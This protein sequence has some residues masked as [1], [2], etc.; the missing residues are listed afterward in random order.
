M[1]ALP[2]TALLAALSLAVPAVTEAAASSEVIPYYGLDCG[3]GAE[4]DPALPRPWTNL[5][6][7]VCTSKHLAALH[8]QL[9]GLLD[10]AAS[11]LR[12][13][14]TERAKERCD[15]AFDP[16]RDLEAK[17]LA[18]DC[19]AALYR[20]LIRQRGSR[21][22]GNVV[23]GPL[24]D[25]LIHP[26][27]LDDLL[28]LELDTP[29]RANLAPCLAGTKRVTFI[30]H[31]VD[32]GNETERTIIYDRWSP[33][34]FS[35]YL[36]YSHVGRPTS[37]SDLLWTFENSGGR[38]RFHSL[39][40]VKG[41]LARRERATLEWLR[42][43]GEAYWVEVVGRARFGDRCNGSLARVAITGPT[44]VRASV[45][46]TPFALLALDA[47]HGWRGIAADTLVLDGDT[48]A[49]AQG[50]IRLEAGRDL[51]NDPLACIGTADFLVDLATGERQFTGAVI[52]ELYYWN[53]DDIRLQAC[54]NYLAR[55]K[56]TA[57][58]LTLTPQSLATLRD[59]FVARCAV[60]TSGTP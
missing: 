22:V 3:G 54:F 9:A 11:D 38:A 49:A 40:L 48:G 28:A 14:M 18:S 31:A 60:P 44:T 52:D 5:N 12:V 19:L 1:R 58:P 2:A 25:G 50:P 59:A 7:L 15:L 30:Y 13:A 17:W 51:V 43:D 36:G 35:G 55:S 29:Y 32:R 33:A 47:Y 34:A 41:L 23:R 27:C 24:P 57:M 8:E 56:A 21:P 6:R 10:T 53:I 45:N 4:G 37:D 20:E 26:A 42:D 46:I 39:A 16:G